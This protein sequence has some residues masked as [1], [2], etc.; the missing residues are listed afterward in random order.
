MKIFYIALFFLGLHGAI[1]AQT[2]VKLKV[3]GACGM[4]EDRIETNALNVIGVNSADWDEE[5]EILT[6]TVAEG[7]FLEEDMHNQM[8]AIG[9]DTDQ[10]RA[11]DSVYDNLHHCCKYDRPEASKSSDDG[12][13]DGHDHDDHEG[14]D[15]D[16]HAGHDHD[17]H[18]GHDH[19]KAGPNGGRLIE[20][21]NTEFFVTADKNIQITFYDADNKAITPPTKSVTVLSGPRSAPVEFTFK[22]DGTKLVSTE[23]LPEGNNFPTA[24]ELTYPDDKKVESRFNLDLSNCPTCENLEYA[25]ECHH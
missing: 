6:L 21:T 11:A 17:D 1:S 8:V 13:H 24:V 9:H 12:D 10:K 7:M 4:C 15:H 18:E 3:Y 19:T 2:E 5:T 14:H 22:Q 16:D 23:T 25:C 20:D